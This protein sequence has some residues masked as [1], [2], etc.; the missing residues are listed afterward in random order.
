[1]RITLCQGE[2]TLRKKTAHC[3][4]IYKQ[5]KDIKLLGRTEKRWNNNYG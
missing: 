2:H 3:Q 5:H 4:W 1:M